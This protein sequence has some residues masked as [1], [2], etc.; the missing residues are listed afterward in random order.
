[1]EYK[2]IV[3]IGVGVLGSQIAFQCAYSGYETTLLIR[4]D[5]NKSKI[6]D[7]NTNK[8]EDFCKCS[9]H[10]SGIAVLKNNKIIKIL[11]FTYSLITA[12]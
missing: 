10:I 7:L 8:C 9:R 12:K 6:W 1:M 5:D 2:K 4:E 11:Y 3:I